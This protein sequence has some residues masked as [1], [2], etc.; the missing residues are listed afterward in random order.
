MKIAKNIN[1]QKKLHK[2]IENSKVCMNPTCSREG[3]Y[4]CGVCKER[5]CAKH[6]DEHYKNNHEIPTKEGL[7]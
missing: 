4:L 5:F 6:I 3:I 2:Q 7:L 1:H